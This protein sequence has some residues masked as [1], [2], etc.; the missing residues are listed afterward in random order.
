VFLDQLIQ[1]V[2][3]I[4]HQY[5]IPF[6]LLEYLRE[7]LLQLLQGAVEGEDFR[8]ERE[9]AGRVF[10]RELLFQVGKQELDRDYIYFYVH[11]Y[12]LLF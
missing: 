1:Q 2:Q 5:L 6:K 10:L 7:Q 9:E 8:A 4:A 12:R 3:T 11:F